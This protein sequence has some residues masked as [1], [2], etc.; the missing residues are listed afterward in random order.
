[1]PW[2]FLS[3]SLCCM[4]SLLSFNGKGTS[5][6][7]D[8]RCTIVAGISAIIAMMAGVSYS[9]EEIFCLLRGDLSQTQQSN[10]TITSSDPPPPWLYGVVACMVVAEIC[11]CA[12]VRSRLRKLLRGMYDSDREHCPQSAS[13]QTTGLVLAR[14]SPSETLYQHRDARRPRNA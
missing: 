3:H 14:S 13:L 4:C 8:P 11:Q 2:P 6:S 7:V 1:M 9:P 12:L 5:L 10:E